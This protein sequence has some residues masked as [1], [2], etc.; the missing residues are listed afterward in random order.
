[1]GQDKKNG[2]SKLNVSIASS[3]FLMTYKF[4]IIYFCCWKRQK[5]IIIG[6]VH[7]SVAV[8]AVPSGICVL[9][10]WGRGVAL[11]LAG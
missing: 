3:V 10:G 11:A 6:K 8:L 9:G 1:M 4:I 2:T 7:S 5:R